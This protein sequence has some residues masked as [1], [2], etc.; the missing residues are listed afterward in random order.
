MEDNS[1]EVKEK[2]FYVH[3]NGGTYQVTD[4][5]LSLHKEAIVFY[6]HIDSDREFCR[7]I[8]H[9]RESFKPLKKNWWEK[10]ENIGKLIRYD[11]FQTHE[12]GIFLGVNKDKDWLD[13]AT[14]QGATCQ[15]KV[16]KC[17]IATP[18]ECLSLCIDRED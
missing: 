6:K 10:E 8:S 11:Y 14:L 15:Q 5:A 18:E 2:S 9:F 16:R 17:K 13:I 7:T 3:K 1:F 12:L 4:K